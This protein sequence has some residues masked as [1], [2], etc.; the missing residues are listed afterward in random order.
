MIS[1]IK[2]RLAEICSDSIVV[3]AGSIGVNIYIPLTFMQKLPKIGKEVIV[4]TYFK[5]SEDSLSL[6]G[7][8]NRQELQLFKQVLSVNGIGPKGAL[9]ILSTLSGDE[10]R[11]AVITE[12]VKTVSK[13][14]GIGVKTA[15]RL[16]LDLKDKIGIDEILKETTPAP[17]SLPPN[18][19][20]KELEAVEALYSLGYSTSEAA[21]AVKE[22]EITE[23]MTAE[24]ILKLALKKLAVF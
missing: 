20:G 10:L 9:A 1:Y 21:K 22:I 7:F 18:K 13:A 14:P 17:A 4:Y 5:V 3:E 11:A 16:I 6:Y 19:A 23:D 24:N 12:D 15:K 2:G 8:E